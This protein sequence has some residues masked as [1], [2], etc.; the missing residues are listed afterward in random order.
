MKNLLY[1]EKYRPKN[2]KQIILLPRI[3]KIFNDGIQ[4]NVLLHGHM[5]TGK[6]SLIRILLKDKTYI[7]INASLKNGV[8]ILREELYDFCV[9]MPSPFNRSEDKMKYVYLEEYEKT[10]PAFQ[11]AFK[12]F[13]E[14]YDNRVRFIITMNHIECVIPEVLSRFNEVDFDPRDEFEKSF[15]KDGYFKYLK[16]VCNHVEKTNEFKIENDIIKN[17]INKKFPDL[18]SSVQDIQQIY[19][20]K[21]IGTLIY[22]SDNNYQYV[23]DFILN[24]KNDSIENFDFVETYFLN[25]TLLLLKILSRP[26]MKYL[27]K[28]KTDI[29]KENGLLLIKLSKEHNESFNNQMVD[30]VI[31]LSNYINELK[32]IL[33]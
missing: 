26:F 9:S 28:N 13:I 19:I 14:E 12:S 15:L 2:E 27:I 3:K 7:K 1:W 10:T 31:H 5:G 4:T 18:R 33:N 20:T 23:Y 17:I 29:F 22:N 21:D 8:D 32:K 24:N 16:L 25:E 11:D 6:T 30:P